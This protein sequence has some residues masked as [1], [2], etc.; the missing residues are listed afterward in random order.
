[1]YNPVN[2]RATLRENK[3]SDQPVNSATRMEI[4]GMPLYIKS[5]E[6]GI[7]YLYDVDTNEHVGYWCQKKEYMLC[8]H[9]MNKF[10]I[11]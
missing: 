5:S 1:M 6:K 10:L 9:R 3:M 11:I 2:L 8:F 4:N 7:P